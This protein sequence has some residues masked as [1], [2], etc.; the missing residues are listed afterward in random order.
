MSA[1]ELAEELQHLQNE[2]ATAATQQLQQQ[3]EARVLTTG[4]V[5]Q[6]Q[7]GCKPALE[8]LADAA[9][10][11]HLVPACNCTCTASHLVGSST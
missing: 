8:P 11:T 5:M 10:H 2:Q 3:D 6:L 1:A 9:S 4:L 7:V